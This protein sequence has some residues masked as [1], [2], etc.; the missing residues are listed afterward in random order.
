VLK[1]GLT[2]EKPPKSED[3]LGV[4][5]EGGVFTND[6]GEMWSTVW[7]S[8]VTRD[9]DIFSAN[10]ARIRV[11]DI[12]ADK[13]KHGSEMG[14][15]MMSLTGEADVRKKQGMMGIVTNNFVTRTE[16]YA[17]IAKTAIGLWYGRD[18]AV[19]LETV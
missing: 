10:G 17:N 5:L 14:P 19:D 13:I 12:I 8:V 3:V 7:A 4:G 9:G 11:A 18:W 15:V 2:Q 16:E 6:N 1:A